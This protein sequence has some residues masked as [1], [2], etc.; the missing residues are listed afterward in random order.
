MSFSIYTGNCPKSVNKDAKY[1][2]KVQNKKVVVVLVYASEDDERWY[3]STSEHSELVKMVND[4]KTHMGGAPNGSFYINEYKQ[5]IVPVA[6]DTGLVK[7]FVA[8]KYETPLIFE[9]EGQIISGK[10]V[11]EHGKMLSPGDIWKG[12]H[13][14]TPYKLS[15]GANDIYYKYSPRPNVEKKVK[16]SKEIGP[17]KAA[18]VAALIKQV[19]GDQGGRFY[20]NEFLTIFAPVKSGFTT[21]YKYI[22]QL[23][24]NEWYSEPQT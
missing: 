3:M 21:E 23:N 22:G 4:V 12:A 16:L 19:K 8:G 15:A 7:Y 10:G 20:V 1:T 9:F 2:V 11:D 13:Q 6:D 5:V 17:I 24:L 14:G 18:R